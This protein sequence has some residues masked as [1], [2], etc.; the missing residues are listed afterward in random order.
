MYKR[1]VLQGVDNVYE[2]DEIRPVIDVA[3][4][5]AGKTYGAPGADGNAHPDDVRL[6]VVA[7]H[8]RSSL[9]LIGDGVVPGNEGRGYVLR[10]MLR[11]AVRSMRL[12]GYEE[13]ALPA[14]LPVSMEK[15]SRSYPELRTDFARIG[16]IAYAEEA[17]SYTH[18]TLPT[19]D[20]V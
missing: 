1:Q 19:S 2:I 15:M 18:L 17:V 4:G 10:R 6:R 14:L 7:D 8:V 5:L 9:M 16:A 12:L 11:R 13:P 3:A 20:L